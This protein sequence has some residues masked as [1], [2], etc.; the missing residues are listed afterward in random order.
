LRRNHVTLSILWE[1]Y[2]EQQP[3]GY[4]Y[5]RFCELS[6][7]WEGKLPLTM[8]QAH[9]GGDKLFVDNASDTVPVVVDQ[10]T[11][12]FCDAQIFVAVMGASSFTYAEATWTQGLADWIGAQA[13]ALEAIGGVPKEC[14][15]S[16][17]GAIG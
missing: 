9:A 4:R 11:G 7:A 6:R 1:E 10:L 16:C 14:Q 17:V 13:R 3:E 12:E 15:E 8:R 2:R 5:S